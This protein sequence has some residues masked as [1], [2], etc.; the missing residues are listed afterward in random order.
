MNSKTAAGGPTPPKLTSRDLLQQFWADAYG[1]EV[2]SA[3]TYSYMWLADQFGHICIGIIL[4]FIATALC[5]WVMVRLGF[6]DKW[7]YNTGIWFGLIIVV[8]VAA[9]WEWCAYNSSVKQATGRFPLDSKLL[10]YNAFIAAT[11]I[12][13]GGVLGFAFHLHFMPAL[14]VGLLVAAVAIVLAPW[15]LR[16]KI[17]W[18][19]ASLPYLFRLA[20]VAAQTVQATDAEVLQQLIDRGAPPSTKACQVVIGGIRPD[21]HGSRNRN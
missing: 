14:L 17:I 6:A 20:D 8:A 19:K 9:I 16:Q 11:Y 15:W 12:A 18:Q 10:G 2:Q 3:A 21:S 13:L 5:G 1:K 7:G 4:N